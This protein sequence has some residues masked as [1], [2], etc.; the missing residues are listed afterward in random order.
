MTRAF[1]E[2]TFDIR[3]GELFRAWSMQLNIFLIITTLLIVKPTVNSLFLS[4]YGIE[5]LPNAYIF[6]AIIAGLVTTAYAKMVQQ[7]RFSYLNIG[8]LLSSVLLLLFFGFA[9]R[10]GLWNQGIMY[11]FYI[12]VAIFA[13]L[14]T[15]QFWLLVN[16]VFNV[17][18]IK[19]LVGFIGSGAIA[20]GIFGGYLTSFLILHTSSKN[21]P[22]VAAFT[23][24]L[25]IPLTIL[26]FY[27]QKKTVKKVP[28]ANEA[29]KTKEHPF[30]IILQSKH[31]TLMACLVAIGN[32]VAKL[33]DYQFSDMAS[34]TISDPEK[35]TAFFGFWFS[36]FNV[37]AFIIQ[38]LLTRI[39]LNRFGVGISLLFLPIAIATAVVCLIIAPELL[40]AV[41]VM[42][43]ADG[44]LKQ[45][46]NKSAMELLVLPIPKDVKNQT[47]TF[48]DVFVDSLAAGFSGLLLIFVIQGLSLST[49]SISALILAFVA[50]WI[51]LVTKVRKEYL[52]SFKMKIIKTI[53]GKKPAKRSLKRK[54]LIGEVT[55]ILTEGNPTQILI[56]LQQIKL[57]KDRRYQ[58]YVYKLL[59]HSDANV[60]TEAI[61]YL[62]HYKDKKA[63]QLID[64]MIEDPT[65]KVQMAAFAY[66]IEHTRFKNKMVIDSHLNSSNKK[67]SGLAL[68]SLAIEIQNNPKLKRRYQ[69]KKR[70]E[71]K[72]SN[73]A[74]IK[75]SKLAYLEK[76]YCIQ[77]I[78]HANIPEL[79]PLLRGFLN[80]R[81]HKP[82]V[83]R[84][85]L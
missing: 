47:K 32:V 15:S 23:I 74:K 85:A 37:A 40:A 43:M 61:L 7:V 46:V 72:V 41:I 45:S 2:K 69:L 16:Q 29:K 62:S 30:R 8:T 58:E 38:L 10:I 67:L 52:Y 77:A 28:T 18:E 4:T 78:G 60:R 54:A 70:I 14:T 6:V 44:A 31:L 11:A 26:I 36:T 59:H 66:L 27:K 1:L 80:D 79:Y 82:I 35:L 19:R 34:S 49:V 63:Y 33:V 42:K 5:S 22:F 65:A 17:R 12:W 25:C 56:A 21:L 76:I 51:F 3:E 48:I 20:G 71:E 64:A 55:N 39:I 73:I 57:W 53:D 9:L 84:Q 81:D 13:V 75:D 68:V 50:L 24:A 83:V